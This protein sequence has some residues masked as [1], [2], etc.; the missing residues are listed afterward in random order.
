MSFYLSPYS[1]VKYCILDK[2]TEKHDCW[3][4]SSRRMDLD[5]SSWKLTWR[6]GMSAQ[7]ILLWW[8]DQVGMSAGSPHEDVI[9]VYQ[10]G[11][12]LCLGLPAQHSVPTYLSV[13]QVVELVMSLLSVVIR[14]SYLLKVSNFSKLCL[15]IW[16]LCIRVL[17]WHKPAREACVNLCDCSF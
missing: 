7:K 11:G 15:L 17:I 5:R 13:W 6:A 12:I 14:M 16:I 9:W 10:A 8:S 4:D 3:K 2:A 1:C